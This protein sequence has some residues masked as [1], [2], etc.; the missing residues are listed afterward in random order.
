[1]RG[2]PYPQPT[3]HCPFPTVSP[4]PHHYPENSLPRVSPQFQ[5]EELR[6]KAMLDLEVGLAHSGR[7]FLCPGIWRMSEKAGV[8]WCRIRQ[9]VQALPLIPCTGS[10]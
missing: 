2:V 10:F 5:E 1:M 7:E 3:A 9:L 8:W 4:S 6:K